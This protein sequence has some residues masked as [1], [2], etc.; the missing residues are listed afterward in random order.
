VQPFGR[1]LA[2]RAD[3]DE[4]DHDLVRAE[5]ESRR[6]HRIVGGPAGQPLRAE[7]AGLRRLQQGEADA[8]GAEQLLLLRHL[9]SAREA[10]DDRDHEWRVIEALSIL[11]HDRVRGGRIALA[12]ARRQ[13]FAQ[14]RPGRTLDPEEPPRHELAVI[15]HADRG[16]EQGPQ[17]GLVRARITQQA[18]WN[19]AAIVQQGEGVGI[20]RRS[21]ASRPGRPDQRAIPPTGGARPMNR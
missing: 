1:R 5:S 7:T 13:Q 10:G 12:L 9:V 11:L 17:C 3:V 20:H 19:G 15:R 2:R 16:L 14:A 4:S 21:L 8:A 6:D 18:G